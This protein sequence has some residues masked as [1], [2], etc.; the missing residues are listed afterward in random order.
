MRV[1]PG[2]IHGEDFD[3]LVVGGGIQGAAICREAASQGRRT[4]LVERR[5]FANGTSSRSS[6]LVHGGVRY[7]E[8]GHFAL[9]REALAERE[10]L[11]L[12]APHLV[13]PL[14]M[15]MPFFRGGAK[16]PL[17]IKLGLRLYA[18]M[19]GRS[20][21]PGPKSLSA[22]DCVARFPAIRQRDL[23]GGAMY[24]DAATRDTE[25]TLAVLRAAHEAG[26]VL[27]NHLEVVGV[28]GDGVVLRDHHGDRDIRVGAAKIVNAAG[29]QADALRRV[30][31]I[32][33]ENLVRVSRGS[34]LVLE[35]LPWETALASFLPDNRIQFVVPHHDGTICGTTDVEEAAVGEPTA[36]E[37]DV[38][39][40]LDALGYLL[41][42]PPGRDR[43]RHTYGGWRSLPA[44]KGPPG[45][46]NR[47][48]FVVEEPSA[49]APVFTVVGG[50]L[51]T[52]RALGER[53][54]HELFGTPP[55]S[56]PTRRAALPGGEQP[57]DRSDPLWKRHGCRADRVRRLAEGDPGLL[58]PLCPHRPFLAAEVIHAL[59]TLGA[60][61][62]EDVMLRRLV[63]SRGPCREEACL[64]R[65]HEVYGQAAGDARAFELDRDAVLAEVNSPAT[66]APSGSGPAR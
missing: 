45:A 15:L 57:G 16:S 28:G 44:G 30:L 54:V 52:H 26:A 18:W 1:D 9:V 27:A 60:V 5:D 12:A 6:R 35:P 66:A 13:R 40:L 53:V 25:L 21:M 32:E 43:V 38:A 4:L 42:E 10:R 24:Y 19:A 49:A 23:R 14:P 7:L 36:P 29:P 37:E 65:A 17:L 62:F 48:A 55:S 2:E 11:L 61:T 3:V 50:K 20:S 64:R 34:H 22:A 31:G 51:T 41:E 33:G 63:D 46:L 47:E 58:D 39:Y 8:R 59:Q 56:S